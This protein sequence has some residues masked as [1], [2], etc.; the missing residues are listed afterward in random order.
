MYA[1]AALASLGVGL[2]LGLALYAWFTLS[3]RR[4]HAVVARD[5][6][7]RWDA[8]L[9]ELSEFERDEQRA[10]PPVGVMEAVLALPARRP[11]RSQPS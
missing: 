7:S 6:L 8:R 3:L 1:L 2:G 10:D 11:R 9:A 5:V 4:F